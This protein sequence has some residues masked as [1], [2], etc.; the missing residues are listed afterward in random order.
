VGTPCPGWDRGKRPA[1]LR[2]SDLPL[3]QDHPATF[4]YLIFGQAVV[5]ILFPGWS[6]YT[7]PQA[8]SEKRYLKLSFQKLQI[9]TGW[10]NS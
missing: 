3:A 2:N 7:V 10:D 9:F 8:F 4:I 1:I 6:F 5:C